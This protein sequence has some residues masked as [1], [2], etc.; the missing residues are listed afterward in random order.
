MNYSGALTA[1]GSHLVLSIIGLMDKNHKKTDPLLILV[2]VIAL[3]AVFLGYLQM[4]WT[5][6]FA[7]TTE[8]KLRSTM[9]S[10]IGMA[11]HS[12][13]MELSILLSLM[14]IA[15]TDREDANYSGFAE[16]LKVWKESTRFP[17]LFQNAY[18][19]TRREDSAPQN[20]MFQW[21]APYG[22]FVPSPVSPLVKEWLE[23]MTHRDH[24]AILRVEE[25]MNQQG[26]FFLPL[27]PPQDDQPLSAAEEFLPRL[28]F[29]LNNDLLFKEVLP[30]FLKEYLSDYPFLLR[31]TET[32]DIIYE[33]GRIGPNQKPEESYQ[34]QRTLYLA[35]LKNLPQ[36]KFAEEDLRRNLLLRIWMILSREPSAAAKDLQNT[37]EVLVFYPGG[38]L[39]EHVEFQKHLNLLVILGF[40][41]LFLLT[42]ILL[43]GLFRKSQMMLIKEKNFVS[44]MSHELRTPLAVIRSSADTLER[45]LVTDQKRIARYGAV[46]S[47]QTRRLSE[48]VEGILLYSGLENQGTS[49]QQDT[50]VNLSECVADTADSLQSLLNEAK[51]ELEK[52]IEPDIKVKINSQAVRLVVE[53]LLSNA[54]K[55]GCGFGAEARKIVMSLYRG[56]ITDMV[57]L[58]ITDHG[59]GVPSR[60]QKKIFHP[61]YRGKRSMSHQI[62][63]SGL[64]LHLVER[65]LELIG[66]TIRVESPVHSDAKGNRWGSRFIIHFP[67]EEVS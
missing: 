44:S 65:T 42:L 50:W 30:Y 33:Q 28:L 43:Y 13:Q 61:F 11:L 20:R 34:L 25:R 38:D 26:L 58:T 15:Q 53:N 7:K 5:D 24:G 66:G 17:S 60:E 37:Y 16:E 27:T 47:N 49:S 35:P 36:D 3:L 1:F 63:G 59:P 64:G 40:Q 56:R 22:T 23:S 12:T 62:A 8:R 54:L 45:G 39:A 21:D 31:E 18:L 32:G 9:N 10:Q 51:A 29:E 41:V 52:E 55:H 6:A 48:H 2:G 19:I 67:N 14:D 4:G 46:I 57:V